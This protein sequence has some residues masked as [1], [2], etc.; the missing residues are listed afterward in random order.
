MLTYYEAYRNTI[1]FLLCVGVGCRVIFFADALSE[2]VSSVVV[3]SYNLHYY[4]Y[5]LC[6]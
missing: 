2:D 5:Y 3:R 1:F 6:N 4:Y